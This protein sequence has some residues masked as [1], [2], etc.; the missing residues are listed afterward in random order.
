MY[1]NIDLSKG[2]FFFVLVDPVKILV[3]PFLNLVS[4]MFLPI[5]NY[6]SKFCLICE[7]CF[8]LYCIEYLMFTKKDGSNRIALGKYK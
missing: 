4:F 3:L 7:I 6:T 8:F 2:F 1:D 5:E